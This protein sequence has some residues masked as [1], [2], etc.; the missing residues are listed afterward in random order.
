M[1]PKKYATGEDLLNKPVTLT[2]ARVTTEQLHPSPM[3]RLSPNTSSGL[4]KPSRVSSSPAPRDP[5]RRSPG[6]RETEM[7]GKRVTSPAADDRRRAGSRRHPRPQA[8][9]GEN[10]HPAPTL[11]DEEE[12][13]A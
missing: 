2:V 13:E 7:T 11:Q 4:T 3:P 12:S 8:A 10:P 6:Q 1:Y 9:N 5:D